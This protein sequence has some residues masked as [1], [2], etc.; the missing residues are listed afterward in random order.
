MQ[1]GLT[2]QACKPRAIASD[3]MAAQQIAHILEKGPPALYRVSKKQPA[4]CNEVLP[5]QN[6]KRE[7]LLC[8]DQQR[9][10]PGLPLFGAWSPCPSGPAAQRLEPALLPS[11]PAAGAKATLRW[12]EP[13]PPPLCRSAPVSGAPA[14]PLRLID[15]SPA[16]S[17]R[18]I[19]EAPAPIQADLTINTS[20]KTERKSFYGSSKLRQ[21]GK[22]L[23]TSMKS[24][25]WWRGRRGWPAGGERRQWTG[26]AEVMTMEA[27]TVE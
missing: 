15:E 16:A 9:P 18:I 12:L 22:I 21:M 27:V 10:P 24:R 7:A 8:W 23:R 2:V 26:T 25:T 17:L 4:R 13:A 14:A 1:S 3:G 5:G 6:E 19:D 20:V 11:G